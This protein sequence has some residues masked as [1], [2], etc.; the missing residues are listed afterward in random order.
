MEPKPID[1]L[2][3]QGFRIKQDGGAYLERLRVR[4]VDRCV[5]LVRVDFWVRVLGMSVLPRRR[6]VKPDIRLSNRVAHGAGVRAV[7]IIPVWIF[8]HAQP[9]P[10]MWTSTPMAA[11]NRAAS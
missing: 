6:I 9:R 4:P 1:R 3:F 2:H 5:D 8:R 10:F 11:I 7:N